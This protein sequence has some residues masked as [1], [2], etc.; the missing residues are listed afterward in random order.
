M[1]IGFDLDKV[2][3]NTPPFIPNALI[4]KLYVKKVKAGIPEYRIPSRKEQLIRIFSHHPLFRP[5]MKKN[6]QYLKDLTKTDH[7]LYLIS[8][9]YGFLRHVTTRL[10]KRH[11]LDK[12]FA[13][14]YFNFENKQAHVF[15]SEVIN[16]L[17]L[18]A[19]VDDD[20]PLLKYVAGRNNQVKLYWL[21]QKRKKKI[22]PNIMAI[23][24]LQQMTQN[25]PGES[26]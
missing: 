6:M 23:T 5:V 10:V 11:K 21:N 25:I 26:R 17:K 2:F 12:I 16:R 4:T 3:I 15:K 14:L 20:L 1:K 7:Q 13:E 18:D 19:Y 8:S 22:S 24:D 9:R